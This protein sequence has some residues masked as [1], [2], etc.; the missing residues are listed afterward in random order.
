MAL[1]ADMSGVCNKGG[2]V[3]AVPNELG[4]ACVCVNREYRVEED[5]IAVPCPRV[6]DEENEQYEDS[7]VNYTNPYCSDTNH[8]MRV[9]CTNA[10]GFTYCG[11]SRPSTVMG[12]GH[13]AAVTARVGKG[14]TVAVVGDGA[15]GLCGVIAAKRLGAERIVILGR[16]TDRTDL[17][18]E[19]GATDVV[20]ER[21]DA[22]V[23]RVR[24]LTGGFGAHAVLECVG[25]EQATRTGIRQLQR[26]LEPH[27]RQPSP[28]R[29]P[30]QPQQKRRRR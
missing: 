28:T 25:T 12:T 14:D 15:V 9:V 8:Q 29:T 27:I 6:D 13:H 19:F 23:E 10:G 2:T 3:A 22:A 4:T 17:A 16:H 21:G 1:V 20:S 26:L 5:C 18:Q 30:D 11:F 24:E 7:C